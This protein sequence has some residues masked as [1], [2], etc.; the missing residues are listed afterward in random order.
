M[1]GCLLIR[2]MVY[3]ITKENNEETTMNP[4]LN[5]HERNYVEAHNSANEVIKQ[6]NKFYE[7]Y[8]KLA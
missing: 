8:S 1:G 2:Q 6:L 4:M 7:H 3:I 5:D